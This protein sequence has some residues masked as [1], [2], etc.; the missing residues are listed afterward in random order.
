MLIN[1]N[2]SRWR[3]LTKKETEL[4]AQ[5]HNKLDLKFNNKYHKSNSTDQLKYP[6]S[7]S[8]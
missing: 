8:L 2:I 4:I 5:I 6:S 3:I 7:K 1:F